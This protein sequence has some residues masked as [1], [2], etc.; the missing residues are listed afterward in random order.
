MKTAQTTYLE[1]R[2]ARMHRLVALGCLVD[3]AGDR[4]GVLGPSI[5]HHARRRQRRQQALRRLRCAPAP[6]MV[7]IEK[8]GP[9]R[10]GS[11][12][13]TSGPMP[14]RHVTFDGF[15]P[16]VAVAGVADAVASTA[17]LCDSENCI[18]CGNG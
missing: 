10:Q 4:V 7:I 12:V 14:G 18:T 15:M 17:G 1:W 5:V 9:Q 8:K 2:L 3:A 16:G 13:A 6:D 11:L